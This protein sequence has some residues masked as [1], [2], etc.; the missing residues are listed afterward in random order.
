[1]L[2]IAAPAWS[3][4]LVMWYSNGPGNASN[5]HPKSEPQNSRPFAVSSAGISKCTGWPGIAPPVASVVRR[6]S[7]LRRS[8]TIDVSRDLSI[9]PVAV[10]PPVGRCQEGRDVAATVDRGSRGQELNVDLALGSVDLRGIRSGAPSSTSLLRTTMSPPQ[11]SYLLRFAQSSP[12]ATR[13]PGRLR[14]ADAQRAG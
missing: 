8:H 6:R 4:I 13:E 10:L 12:I 1:M 7:W 5:C 14:G 2:V 11:V 9:A 3:L